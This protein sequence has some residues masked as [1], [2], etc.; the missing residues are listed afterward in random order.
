MDSVSV[1][2]GVL[3]GGA[4]SSSSLTGI[5]TS[6]S[7]SSGSSSEETGGSSPARSPACPD[8]PTT[9]PITDV[10][11]SHQTP[12]VQRIAVATLN[13]LGLTTLKYFCINQFVIIIDGLVRSL[14]LNTYVMGLRPLEIVSL[15]QWGTVLYIII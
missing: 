7:D 9:Q 10:F 3:A 11:T 2:T 14:H 1:V 6:S 4:S 12:G 5:S 8:T 15:F 13:V